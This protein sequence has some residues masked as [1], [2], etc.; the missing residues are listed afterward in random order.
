MIRTITVCA[1][2]SFYDEV[3]FQHAIAMGSLFQARLRVVLVWEPGARA[4]DLPGNLD[5][6]VREQADGLLKAAAHAGLTAEA[7]FRGEGLPD[8]ALREA[9]E[10]DL[11]IIGMPTEGAA[12]DDPLPRAIL[13]SD[14]PL[15]RKAESAVLV[16]CSPP[17]P[18]DR[19][20]VCYQGGTEGKAALR[21]AGHLA[22]RAQAAVHVL[23]VQGAIVEAETCAATAAEYLDSFDLP[24]L[25]TIPRAGSPESEREVLDAA[26]NIS[27]DTIIIGDE[28]Y[29]II[30]RFFGKATAE[31]IVLKTQTPV[32]VAR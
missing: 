8:G 4:R 10:A 20:L 5:R 31:Q 11:L 23:S 17:K 2:D 26:D 15:L 1:G 18:P 7:R 32:L 19:V 28:P 16:V 30:E 6:Y 3:A 21:L 29:G 24:R 25:E 22:E 27:A 12:H 13:S 9:R 14:L